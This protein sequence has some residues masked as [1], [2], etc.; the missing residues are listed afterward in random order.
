MNVL[1]TGGVGYI[2]GS[3]TVRELLNRHHGVVVVDNLS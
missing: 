2:I 1:V 3:Y